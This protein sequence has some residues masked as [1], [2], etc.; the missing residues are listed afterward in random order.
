MWTL[1]LILAAYYCLI[2]GRPLLAGVFLGLA[3]GFRLQSVIL[4]LPFA[5]IL[6][7]QGRRDAL[8]AFA[9][10][11]GGTALLAFAPVL[12][13]YGTGFLNYYDASVGYQDVLRLLGKE[14]LGV[15]GVLGVLAGG[16]LSI[17]RLARLP[18]DAVTDPHLGVWLLAI[19]LYFASFSRL[20]RE[21]AYLVPVFPFGFLLLGRYCTRAGLAV[22][23]GA[24]LVAGVV[25]VTTPGSGIT[26][27][28][29]RTA[30]LGKGLVFS[31]AD[32]MRGQRNFVEQILENPTPDHSV[33]LTG[34]IFP[35]LVIRE[36]D[37][38]ENRILERD[39]E[40]IS[41][42]SDRG[43]GVDADRDIRYVWLLTYETFE[44]LRAQGYSF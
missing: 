30:T 34:F 10:A 39:Y 11:A 29:L 22:A 37:R 36:R 31:N 43:E 25:D 16:A 20:P 33:V 4:G 44:A 15:L 27:S 40:A 12:A 24:I 1:T 21:I 35:Q 26:P 19:V 32:T 5:Y 2:T 28:E 42:L 7:R 13:V 41:M 23:V 14:A 3:V 18:R 6:W 17:H 8:P 38:L 9:L